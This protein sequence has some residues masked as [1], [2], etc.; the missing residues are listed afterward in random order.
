LLTGSNPALSAIALHHGA[1]ARDARTIL[2][3]GRDSPYLRGRELC[4]VHKRVQI[5]FQDPYSSLN[6]R[7]TIAKTIA[8]PLRLYAMGE[9]SGRR[10]RVEPQVLI[11]DEPVSALDVSV[12]AQVINLLKRLQRELGIAYPF[13]SHNL[14][15]VQQ[16]ADRIS[17]MYLGRIVELAEGAAM[18]KQA[19]HPYTQ[20]LFSAMPV[21]DPDA[22]A[23]GRRRVVLSG[24]VPSAID[25]PTGCAFAPR[26]R[27][28][29]EICDREPLP[30]KEIEGRR[31]RCHFTGKLPIGAVPRRGRP[32]VE[33][34]PHLHGTDSTFT[35]LIFQP[36]W[37]SNV[38]T[39]WLARRI[40]RRRAVAML[41]DLVSLALFLRAVETKSL[42]KAATQSHIALAAAS[43]RIA[44]LEHRY[45]VRLLYRSS[46]GV[47]PTPAG[48]A[49]ALHARR[50]I[51][52]A[53]RL[54]ADLADYAKGV[55]GHIRIKANTSA[56]TQYLPQDLA[57]FAAKYP[58]VR[59]ELEECRSFEVVQAL[60]EGRADIGVVMD[61]VG[62]EGLVSYEYRH[63]R[64]VAVVP[65]GH[66]LRARQASFAQ[67]L[68]Y[69]L[70]ALEGSAA[71]MR[72]LGDAAIG[73]GQP[74]RLR[75]QVKSFEAVCKLVQAGMG[76]GVLPEAA[77]LDFAPVMKLRLVRIAEAWAQR[78]MHVC[79][80]DL[81][82]LPAVGRKLVE[83]MV[84][85]EGLRNKR[86]PG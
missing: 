24:E 63:D 15:L 80:R 27:Y 26:C 55:K 44:L 30:F 67:M 51:E 62:V 14:G 74:L 64:L 13:I 79:V 34:N 53:E 38:R 73:V 72:L 42:S 32:R 33:S 52:E 28:R 65:R 57:R 3:A 60:R 36:E 76:I 10:A 83:Q 25:L 59:L 43:R 7:R 85:P 5:V 4:D 77:A 21:A 58:D 69:D 1:R 12:Q 71:M 54:R 17:V 61:G 75:V 66:E 40:N 29:Q 9:R 23:R 16:I 2:V 22:T 19:M 50:M 82:G 37:P 47:E 48:V 84:D 31:V 68:K 86:S 20:A 49:L 11:C 39:G 35:P 56:I 78:R 6:P 81:E 18:R 8:D 41:P 70:V 46:Q 45:G